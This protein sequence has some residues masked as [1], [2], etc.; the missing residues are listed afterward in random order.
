MKNI[1]ATLLCVLLMSSCNDL[2]NITPTGSVQLENYQVK[3]NNLR[4]TLNSLYALLQT[5]DYQKSELIF[6]ECMSDNAYNLQDNLGGEL[7]QL[8]NFEFN[9]ENSYIKSKYQLNYRGINI[10]NQI[11]SAA[12]KVIYNPNYSDGAKEIREVLGQAKLFRALFYFNLVRTFGGVSIQPETS[13]LRTNV[14]PRST[15][16]EIYALIEK[17]LREACLILYRDR[18]KEGSAGQAS[19]GAGLGLLI[20]VLV[21]QASP[22]TRLV[23]PNRDTK[24]QEAKEIA[25]LFIDG[26]ALSY[27]QILKFSDRYNNETWEAL[28]KRL[29]LTDQ[30]PAPETMFPASDVANVHGLIDYSQLFRLKNRFNRESLL[31]INHYD[32]SASGSSVDK[33]NYLYRCFNSNEGYGV[34]PAPTSDVYAYRAKDPRG[35]YIARSNSDNSDFYKDENGVYVNIGWYN[36]AYGYAFCKYMVF[37]TEGSVEQRTYLIM[38][39]AEAL[40]FYAEILNETGDQVKA[41]EE[42]NKIRARAKKLLD[43]TH[44]DSKYNT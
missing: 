8:L 12:S 21:Y 39:Y 30:N 18:Y 28:C 25:E 6:G 9:A 32:Y 5:E 31:E 40:L 35:I 41:T 11:I 19:I 27:D 44:P 15:P 4:I 37:N 14:I 20:K 43:P 1:I 42:L 2:F 17:D 3:L 16:D 34:G 13:E 24:W 26:K 10:A 36:I 7:G 38:R 29:S 22:G 33:K 23:S